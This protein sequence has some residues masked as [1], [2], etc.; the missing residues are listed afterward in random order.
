[1]LSTR[2]FCPAVDFR[3]ELTDVEKGIIEVLEGLDIKEITFLGLVIICVFELRELK[4]PYP[5]M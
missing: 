3:K 2:S 5:E 4:Y 1:M